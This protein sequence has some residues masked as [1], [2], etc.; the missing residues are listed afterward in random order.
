M[1]SGSRR[2]TSGMAPISPTASCTIICVAA[3]ISWGSAAISPS[4]SPMISWIAL[5]ASCGRLWIRKS[6]SC[7]TSVVASSVIGPM[8]AVTA[9]TTLCSSPIAAGSSVVTSPGSLLAIV[10]TSLVMTSLTT[11][12][13]FSTSPIT[14]SSASSTVSSS[15]SISPGIS[16]GVT[17]S[18]SAWATLPMLLAAA[19]TSGWNAGIITRPM[20]FLSAVPVAFIFCME[21]SKDPI[22]LRF[23]S[24]NTVPMAAASLPRSLKALLPAW[25]S[26]FSSLALFPKS[27][28][29]AASRSLSFSI[30]PSASI[31]D[32]NTVSLSS[33]LPLASL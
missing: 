8:L 3:G 18:C 23:S 27:A 6:A 16:S 32:Q 9:L 21:S 5:S 30:L 25:I 13:A 17:P 15:S 12:M 1:I 28:M 24:E 26:G 4:A 19:S 33:R 22:L 14:S 11:G 10:P 20:L 29:A 2:T 31:A 7:V